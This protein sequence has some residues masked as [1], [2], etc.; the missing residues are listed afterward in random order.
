[1]YW[2]EIAA[3][4]YIGVGV[5]KFGLIIPALHFSVAY[6]L[7]HQPMERG[8]LAYILIYVAVTILVAVLGWPVLLAS[9]GRRFWS[10]YSLEEVREAIDAAYNRHD[11]TD[12]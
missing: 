6:S 11:H 10:R 3:L 1:M 8:A 7:Y 12:L 5:I 4:S 2:Y 9:E